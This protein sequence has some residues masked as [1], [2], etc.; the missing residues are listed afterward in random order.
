MNAPLPTDMDLLEI[1]ARPCEL[2]GLTIDRHD[3]VDDGDGP[4]FFCADI[5]PDEMTLDELERRAELIRQEG[6][7]AIIAR[8]EAM[9]AEIAARGN[10]M[11][12][13]EPEQYRPA[14]STIMAFQYLVA[15][16]DLKR[17]ES[18][19]A[20]RPK[21]APFLLALLEGPATC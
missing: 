14:S 12:P 8:W 18:W 10:L 2:C 1:D 19:L 13:R 9:D 5:L 7:A 3:I 4:L 21:D 11:P 17:L 15:L 16:G 6:V 20:A